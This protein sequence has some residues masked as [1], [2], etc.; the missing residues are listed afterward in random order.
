MLELLSALGADS[1]VACDDA[2]CAAGALAGRVCVDCAAE[3]PRAL[4]LVARPPEGCARAWQLAA[5]AGPGGALVRAAK[6]GGDAAT[7]QALSRRLALAVSALQLLD[8]AFDATLVVPVPA[9]RWRTAWRGLSLPA[10]CAR[11]IVELTGLALAPGLERRRGPA[12]A[13]LPRARRRA[14]ARGR[15]QPRAGVELAGRSVLLVDDVLTTG[16][17]LSACARAL[18]E[19]GARRVEA[20]ALAGPEG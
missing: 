18:L 19:A 12:Q 20:V 17:T 7:A 14:N 6:Y 9:S 1:C 8:P 11:G 10:V 13:A 4:T 15:F 3:V 5:Y 2:P 16:A